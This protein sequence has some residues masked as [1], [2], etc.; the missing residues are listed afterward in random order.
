MRFLPSVLCF[1]FINAASAST[2]HVGNQSF[3][4]S[5]KEAVK[6]SSSNDSIIIHEGVYKENNIVVTH[7]I[8]ITGKN[9][10][11]ID[12]ENKYELMVISSRNVTVTGLHFRNSGYSALNDFASIKII[13]SSNISIVE[14]QIDNAYFAIHI[15]NSSYCTI[16]CNTINGLRKDEQT[17]GNGIHLWK[18]NK[19]LVEGNT[20]TN[21]RDG[22]YFEFVTESII[23][24]NNSENNVRYGLHFMFS[25]KDEYY[26]NLFLNN[27]AGVAVMYSKNVIMKHNDFKYNWGPSAYGLLLKD[28]TD[29]EIQ[30]NTFTKN[31]VGI[32]MEGSNRLNINKNSFMEN[33]WA[34]K[35]QSNCDD[36]EFYNNNFYGNTFDVSTSGSLVLSEFYNNYW[37]KYEGFDLNKDGIGDVPYHPVSLYS[38][39]I[40]NNP[41]TLLLLKSFVIMLLDK[42][43]KALPTLTPESLR[44]DNP[45]IKPLVI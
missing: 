30:S 33:G 36:N 4:K 9:S 34:L 44:D 8:V 12:G 5:I 26:H 45:C 42:T 18:C 43:E 16:K 41:G 25:H 40:E 27:G 14:N 35:V 37:D 7:P 11:I 21:H 20:I 10:P 6:L 28:I 31:T 3:I 1:I 17:T 22:I 23:Q 2:F 29:S 19:A 32:Y 15:S 38:M 39:I 13:N 24:K